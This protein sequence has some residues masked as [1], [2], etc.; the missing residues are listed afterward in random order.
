M[1]HHFVLKTIIFI[2]LLIYPGY[3]QRSISQ[4]GQPDV[5]SNSGKTH[6]LTSILPGSNTSIVQPKT[7][8]TNSCGTTSKSTAS[9]F[10]VKGVHITSWVAGSDS[11][12]QRIINLIKETE[13]NTV[14]IDLKEVDGVIGYE[15]DVPLAKEIKATQKRIRDIDKVISLCNEYGIY[16]IARITVFKDNYLAGK[17]PHLAVLDKSGNLW[18]DDDD[19]AWVNP[20]SKEVWEY[21]LAIAQDAVKHG[22]DEIQFDYVRFPSDGLISNCRYGNGTSTGKPA[23]AIIEF[24][25]FAKQK[26]GTSAFL[27][28]D[29]FGLTTLRKDGIGIGQKFKEIAENID[30]ISPMIYPS[31]YAK[32]SYGMAD[33]DSHPYK[34]VSLSL[35]DANQ[36]IKGTNCKI[37]PWLQDFSLGYSYGAKEVRDQINAAYAQGLDEWLLWNPR[38]IYTKKALSADDKIEF[39][40]NTL[41]R[42]L[43]IEINVFQ[44]LAKTMPLFYMYDPGMT[45]FESIITLKEVLVIRD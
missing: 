22:F 24:V 13:L 18:H 26:L 21:N 37:R 44:I 42:Q 7:T 25:K 8:T 17:K 38:C 11:L 43:P 45:I 4:V 20:Y 35:R 23:D 28:V 29:V 39:V 12:F 2:S 9:Q 14:V 10:K 31:H 41:P 3:V 6:S 33:P 40:K 5:K 34:T 32:G 27:S 16:K 30:F 19:R 15:V 36:Q 1:N